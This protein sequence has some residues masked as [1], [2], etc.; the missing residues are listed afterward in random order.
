[1][2]VYIVLAKYKLVSVLLLINSLIFVINCLAR[3]NIIL[4]V[5]INDFLQ[6]PLMVSC[7]V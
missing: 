4:S 2:L 7:V 6:L 3:V 5:I 1:M